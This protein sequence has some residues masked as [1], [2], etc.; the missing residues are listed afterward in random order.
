MA[1][2]E[3]FVFLLFA[4]VVLAGLGLR[5][6]VP[7]P[8]VL[9]LGGLVI[10]LIPGVPSPV[11]DPEI[12]LFVFLPPLLYASAISVSARELRAN[13]KPIGLLAVG[14]VL[15]TIAAVAAVANAVMGVPW[16]AAF[17]L[18]AVLGPTD[19]VSA[20]AVLDRLGVT[21]RAKTILQ[22][23]S[24]IN[25]ATGLTAYRLALGAVGA[26][27]GSVFE[28]GLEFV[29][30]AAGGIAI[31]LAAGWIFAHVRRIVTDPSL[32]VA[33][34]LLTPFVAYV[35]AEEL[36]VSGV[37]ATVTAGLYVGARSLDIIEPTTRLRTLAFWE[38]TAFLLDG[39]LFVLIG[40]QVPSIIERIE[41]ADELTLALYA[42]LITAVV[43][44]VRA[45][46]MIVIPKLLH[47]D[48]TPAERIVIAW[49]GMRGGVSLAAALAITVDGFPNRDLVI[50]VAYAAI[51]LTLV[52]PGLTL[53]ALI[54]RL[55]LAAT[56]THRREAA[57]ARLKLTR[58]ALERLDE[59]EDDAPEHIVQ[60]LRDRYGSRVER[61]EA[62]LDG[63]EDGGGD[64]TAAAQLLAE[65][66]E[67]ERG[68]LRAMRRE[69]AFA[70]DILRE[71]ERELDLDDSRLRA[72]IQL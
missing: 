66:I 24:L 23:E 70:D 13:A 33:L 35:P 67:A 4:V 47:S 31:G 60:R 37:L 19:P 61:L 14:L 65:M 8:V 48:T 49:S 3:L 34:S 72:R 17:V 28:I 50:F 15:V 45:L 69:R 2:V 43:M 6:G 57:E 59:L 21:G 71:V 5:S 46:W 32:D 64:V 18:G 1:E 9:V 7:Y 56:D 52:L 12:I 10:G 38:S 54:R 44:G 68:L 26:S 16:A 30:V 62:R 51:V 55:G 36:H 63:D 27:A 25:D 11:V 40:L 53:S 29:G 58:A 22:G 42:L 41:D 39:L 20:A